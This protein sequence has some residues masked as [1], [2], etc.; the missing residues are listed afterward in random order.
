MPVFAW[1]LW[2]LFGGTAAGPG[3]GAAWS[4]GVNTEQDG[5][6][7]PPF[8]RLPVFQH[9]PGPLVAP[10]LFRPVPQKRPLP[11]G[12]TALLLPPTRP[13]Q[14]VPGIGARAVQ[15][16]CGV[17]TVSVRVDLFQLPAWTVP[18]LFRLG[19][20][21]ASTISPRFLYFHYRLTE[22]RGQ[23]QVGTPSHTNCQLQTY[24]LTY[25]LWHP[26]MLIGVEVLVCA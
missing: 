18:S 26:A 13:H 14:G 20:C 1:L 6:A 22:C 3:P 2:A 4:E 19:S 8:Y 23:P 24:L 25:F 11:A 17:D 10:E 21:S 15:V 12:L 9:A 5:A 7:R 16:R